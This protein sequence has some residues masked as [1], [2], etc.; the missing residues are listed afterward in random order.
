M[1]GEIPTAS[2]F[3]FDKHRR[4][5]NTLY[6]TDRLATLT[7]DTND[8]V[9]LQTDGMYT[10]TYQRGK[11]KTRLFIPSLIISRIRI[12]FLSLS[13]VSTGDDRLE[14]SIRFVISFFRS[15]KIEP[16]RSFE[17]DETRGNRERESYG[18]ER[19]KKNL[20]T[21]TDIRKFGAFVCFGSRRG[22][23]SWKSVKFE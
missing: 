1:S 20:T 5:S 4:Q 3:S 7:Y 22:R 14:R 23:A 8:C 18:K 9:V 6:S 21:V 15:I 12:F 13:F 10:I 17:D 19:R 16:R 2:R 11:M